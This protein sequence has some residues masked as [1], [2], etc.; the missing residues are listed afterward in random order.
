M[1]QLYIT[2][3]GFARMFGVQ[4]P[5]DALRC[6]LHTMDCTIEVIFLDEEKVDPGTLRDLEELDRIY[7]LSGE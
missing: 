7:Q 6:T 2:R 4:I 1:Q 5:P 3:S